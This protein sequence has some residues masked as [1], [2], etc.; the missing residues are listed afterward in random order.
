M[1][2]E[3]WYS[4]WLP[5]LTIG[6]IEACISEVSWFDLGSFSGLSDLKWFSKFENGHNHYYG[7]TGYGLFN[8]GIQN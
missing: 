6:G 3:L 2:H 1:Y 8:G 4:N 7:N 5:F